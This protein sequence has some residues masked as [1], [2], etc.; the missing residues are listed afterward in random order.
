MCKNNY[1]LFCNQESLACSVLFSKKICQ[2]GNNLRSL[3]DR[4]SSEHEC[5]FSFTVHHATG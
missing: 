5:K 4:H 3:K 2:A 1:N